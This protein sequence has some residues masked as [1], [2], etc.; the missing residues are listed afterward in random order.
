MGSEQP[1]TAKDSPGRRKSWPIPL[2]FCFFGNA[3][4]DTNYRIQ[5]NTIK[6]NF[7]NAH[8]NKQVSLADLIVLGGCGAV[9]QAAAAAGYNNLE[10]PFTVGRVDATQDMTDIASFENLNPQGDGFRNFRSG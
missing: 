1:Q 5:L 3:A 4:V 10:V 8:H 6:T 2:C 7:N 9:E